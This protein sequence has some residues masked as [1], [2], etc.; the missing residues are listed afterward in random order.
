MSGAAASEAEILEEVEGLSGKDLEE[1]KLAAQKD[2]YVM[3]VGVLG[4]K[5]VNP[6][7]HGGFC[8]FVQASPRLRRLGL[9]PRAHLKSTIATV[10][11]SIRL[12]VD[13][14]DETRVL[15]ASETITLAEKFLGQIRGHF[16]SNKILQGLFPELI[17]ERFT[18]PGVTWR[19]DMA[20]LRRS[21]TLDSPTWQAIGVGGAIVGSHFTR[22]K[23][24]DLIGF[25]ALRSPATMQHTKQWVDHIEPLLVNQTLDIIDFIGTRWSKNDLYA[26][27]MAGY[28]KSLAVFTR[29][30]IENGE[31][32]FPALHTWEEY[33]RIQRINPALWAAQYENNPL[34]ETQSDFNINNVLHYR[35][36]HDEQFVVTP[37]GRRWPIEQLDRVLTADPNGGSLAAPDMAAISVQA[38]SPEDEVFVLE[39]W[40]DRATPSDFVDQIYRFARRWDVRIVGIE[41]AGQQ[42]TDHYFRLKAERESYSVKVEQLIP[43]KQS[44]PDRIRGALEPLIRSRLLHI[45]PSQTVLRQQLSDFPDTILWDELDALAY[46]PRLWRKPP[47]KEEIEAHEGS[48][49]RLLALRSR[50]TGY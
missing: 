17:P 34:A 2:L 30:A 22:I 44:K 3:S 21:V 15:I 32:I 13:A 16:E 40:S 23:C 10:A 27:L 8:R 9:M 19:S 4:F 14:P 5:D 7:T 28:G 29:R 37:R 47:R 42:N 46:G 20:T 1:L 36:T 50:I 26:H 43:G 35:F 39:S 38:M 25:E 33:E 41:K 11:D 48:T 6:A 49:K 31:I 18:G 45:L 12:G 24:D